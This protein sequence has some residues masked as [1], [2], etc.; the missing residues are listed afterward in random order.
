MFNVIKGELVKTSDPVMI[1]NGKKQEVDKEKNDREKEKTIDKLQRKIEKK[2]KELKEKSKKLSE[3]E[4]QISNK[5][6]ENQKKAQ[7]ILDDAQE[8]IKYEKEVNQKRGYQDGYQEGIKKGE[9]EVIEKGQQLFIRAQSIIDEA[10]NIKKK[11][12]EDNSKD[13]LELALKIAKKI[14]K[15]EVEKDRDIVQRNLDEAIKKI[16]I[17]KKITIILNWEDLEYIKEI[18]D[19]LISKIQGVDE[20]DIT[21]DPSLNKG[22]CILETSIG[23][24]DASINSQM[25]ILYNK[26]LNIEKNENKKTEDGSE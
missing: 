18:K 14:I 26:L 12:L 20:I 2:E 1:K 17:S 5:T 6:Q 7:Q 11:V 3:I 4:K 10:L 23:T 19:D 21:E 22:G 9:E 15:K 16:P 8:K 24:I 13:I 25:E